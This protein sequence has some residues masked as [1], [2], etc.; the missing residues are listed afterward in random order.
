M[1]RQGIIEVLG[2]A[3]DGSLG[4]NDIDA[5]IASVLADKAA[6]GGHQGRPALGSLLRAAEALKIQL[7][8][9]SNR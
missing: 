7:A 9:P 4:G 1:A 5:A 3:G 8:D 2:T 6:R